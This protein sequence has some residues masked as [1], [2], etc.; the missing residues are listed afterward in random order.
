MKNTYTHLIIVLAVVLSSCTAIK[1]E[2]AA[3]KSGMIENASGI[4][5]NKR[6]LDKA[7]RSISSIEKELK[8]MEAS[9]RSL[10]KTVSTLESELN[11]ATAR[12]EAAH[13]ETSH[14]SSHWDY[15]HQSDWVIGFGEHQSPINIAVSS[16][17]S[18]RTLSPI[19]VSYSVP[20]KYVMDNGHAIV[21]GAEGNTAVINGRSFNLLQFH[22]HSLSEHTV[23]GRHYALEGHFVHS[24]EDGRLAVIGVMMKEGAVNPEFQKILE[25]IQSSKQKDFSLPLDYS[26]LLPQH[27]AYYHYIGSLT[28]P[29][30]TENV[31]WYVLEDPIEISPG[32]VA[33]FQKF[34]KDNY[35][36]V[37]ELNDRVVLANQ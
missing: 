36:D 2:T 37:Q 13:G 8:D 23:N 1:E 16:V 26:K 34:Y 15:Q 24:G 33:Q 22:Y 4:R 30:L 10:E 12:G 25:N 3:L 32:Q 35:R 6:S 27:L 28:T 5:D 29:P 7:D 17:K 14:D 11:R 19:R 18:G 20:A 31:E 9:F 21:V